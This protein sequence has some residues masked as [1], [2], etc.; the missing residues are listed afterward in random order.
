[1]MRDLL[2]H[3]RR[4]RGFNLIEV[5]IAL[6]LVVMAGAGGVAVFA[7]AVNSQTASH[8]TSDAANIAQNELQKLR[9]TDASSV[10]LSHAAYTALQAD[11]PTRVEWEE[12]LNGATPLRTESGIVIPHEVISDPDDFTILR[13]VTCDTSSTTCM[14]GSRAL[15]RTVNLLVKGPKDTRVQLAA[16]IGNPNVGATPPSAG[17]PAAPADL[18]VMQV[19]DEALDVNW[20]PT[21]GAAT[22]DITQGGETVGTAVENRFIVANAAMGADGAARTTAICVRAV[23]AARDQSAQT[24]LTVMLRPAALTATRAGS[25]VNLSWASAAKAPSIAGYRVER[26]QSYP[27]IV[28]ASNPIAYWRLNEPAGASVA[29]DSSG[30]G[31][32]LRYVNT[33]TP[34]V[35]GLLSADDSTAAHFG[36]NAMARR[37]TPPPGY[38]IRN[39][40]IEMW[41]KIDAL[42]GRGQFLKFGHTGTNGVGTGVGIGYGKGPNSIFDADGTELGILY[43][44]QRWIPTGWHF[45]GPGIYHITLRIDAAG[46][47]EVAVNGAPI[48]SFPGTA[49]YDPAG[50]FGLGANV[51]PGGRQFTSGGVLD[52]VA[53]YDRVVPDAELVAHY[54]AGIEGADWSSAGPMAHWKFQ[55]A[56]TSIPDLTGS[57]HTATMV[58]SPPLVAADQMP[59]QGQSVRSLDTTQSVNFVKSPDLRNRNFSVAMWIRPVARTGCLMEAISEYVAGQVVHLCWSTDGAGH[60][61][62]GFANAGKEVFTT[63]TAITANEW[64]LVVLTYHRQGGNRMRIFVDGV[65]RGEM[66]DVGQTGGPSPTTMRFNLYNGS[67]RSSAQW[68]DVAVFSNTLN[69]GRVSDMYER[70]VERLWVDGWKRISGT[71]PLT[72][73]AFTHTGGTCGT[74]YRVRAYKDTPSDA[75]LE[76]VDVATSRAVKAC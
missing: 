52:E 7:V 76:G 36:S 75:A 67:Y 55:T 30:K 56:G 38:N 32:T 2:N 64:H 29:A 54:L 62:A 51:L 50:P 70:D 5:V 22:Y 72:S 16:R 58:G 35:P 39:S 3:L 65:M 11:G 21:D 23:N 43:E 41:V 18:T 8:I 34:G 44:A 13:Y 57:G 73:G 24:C 63:G 46:T 74:F 68:A 49:P 31:N 61:R 69:A 37:A 71:A 66:A 25:S 45:P 60:L 59:F 27:E 19:A 9:A 28:K 47:P 48:G 1:M 10:A 15:P 14:D 12:N 33:A 26:K 4:S 20:A 6:G 53:V 40:T 17:T 42:P